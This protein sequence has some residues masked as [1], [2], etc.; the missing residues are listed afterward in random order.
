MASSRRLLWLLRR[1]NGGRETSG[2][3]KASTQHT[4]TNPGQVTHAIPNFAAVDAEKKIFRGGQPVLPA[5]WEWLKSQG[6]NQVIKLNEDSEGSDEGALD[7]GLLLYKVQIPAVQ[8]LITKP[9]GQYLI[10]AVGFIDEGTF[11]HCEHGRDRTGLVC[12]LYRIWKCGWD[13]RDAEEE[14][15]RFGFHKAL[16]GLWSTWE[17]AKAEQ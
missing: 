15:L 6:V 11:I 3:A 1:G 10:D 12:A 17:Q 4:G 14:M 7:C 2:T 9:D 16:W 13:K 5:N 8:Q